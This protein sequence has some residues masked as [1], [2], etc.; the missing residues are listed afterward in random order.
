MKDKKEGRKGGGKKEGMQRRESVFKVK[1]YTYFCLGH[2]DHTFVSYSSVNSVW[3]EFDGGARHRKLQSRW[4]LMFFSPTRL[5]FNF[6][7]IFT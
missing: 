5:Y 3:Y 7:G 6:A 1:L 4:M 2:V